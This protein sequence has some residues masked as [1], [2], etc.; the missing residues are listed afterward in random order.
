MRKI[1]SKK[2]PEILLHIINKMED[3]VGQR[4]NIIPDNEYLQ[5]S[6]MKLPEGKT[7]IP[8]KHIKLD[9]NTDIT[10]ESWVVIKGKI[11]AILYD[12]DDT[13]IHEEILNPGDCSVTL[14]GGHNYLCMEEGSV[15]YEYK[16]GPYFGQEKDKVFIK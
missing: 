8:H 14:R 9:R 16:T 13:I 12:L 1:Y 7:F 3:I 5:L 2:N 6:T 10:Q 4:H 11:K 15:V